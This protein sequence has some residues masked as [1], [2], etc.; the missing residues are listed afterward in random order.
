MCCLTDL[1][2]F[3]CVIESSSSIIDIGPIKNLLPC[4]QFDLYVT[5]QVRSTLLNLK[6]H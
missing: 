6:R 5:I 4:N 1:P 3:F 2:H